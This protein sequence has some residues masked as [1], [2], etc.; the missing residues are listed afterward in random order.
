MRLKFYKNINEFVEEAIQNL[1]NDYDLDE[2]Y[3]TLTWCNLIYNAKKKLIDYGSPADPGHA[4]DEI[5]SNLRVAKE[6][7]YWDDSCG[8]IMTTGH[9]RKVYVKLIECKEVIRYCQKYLEKHKQQKE[10]EIKN[11][12]Y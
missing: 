5:F 4:I 12:N 8:G 10:R 2:T 1:K 6:Y 11:D 9:H 7:S 3:D